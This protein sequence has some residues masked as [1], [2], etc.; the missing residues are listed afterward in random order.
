MNRDRKRK[1]IKSQT[2]GPINN[3]RRRNSKNAKSMY[4]IYITPLQMIKAIVQ[5]YARQRSPGGT[6]VYERED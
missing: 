6:H 3:Q 5:T 1:A 2:L 4:S